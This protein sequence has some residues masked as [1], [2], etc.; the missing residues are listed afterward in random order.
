MGVER[1]FRSFFCV[2]GR[3]HAACTFPQL[4]GAAVA[5]SR[6][7]RRKTLPVPLEVIFFEAQLVRAAGFFHGQ[8]P[9]MKNVVEIER[10][11]Q[12]S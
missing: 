11:G 9:L 3:R 6:T 12:K 1:G 10:R 8:C 7:G 5:A 2:P 4:D